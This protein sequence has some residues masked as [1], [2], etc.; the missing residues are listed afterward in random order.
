MLGTSTTD[1]KIIKLWVPFKACCLCFIVLRLYGYTLSTGH[2]CANKD[3]EI[4]LIFKIRFDSDRMNWKQN[5]PN[6]F[7]L[8]AAV[9]T[10]PVFRGCSREEQALGGLL[11]SRCSSNFNPVSTLKAQ[12]TLCSSGL[13]PLLTD[14][15]VIKR[16]SKIHKSFIEHNTMELTLSVTFL[17]WIKS[18]LS[19]EVAS[20]LYLNCC[21]CNITG[22]TADLSL[23]VH[24]YSLR[25][26][27]VFLSELQSFSMPSYLSVIFSNTGVPNCTIYGLICFF[28]YILFALC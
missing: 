26:R 8:Q 23:K 16:E 20:S 18:H 21:H 3:Q 1:G 17:W 6:T 5:P 27:K 11:Q 25:T 19:Q 10:C 13:P 24:D 7:F 12:K 9:I 28:L 15:T 2:W 14:T 22:M 4:P